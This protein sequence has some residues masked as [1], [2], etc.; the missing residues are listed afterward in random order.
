[1][2]SARRH[3][4][5]CEAAICYTGRHPRPGAH[6]IQPELLRRDGVGAGADGRAH[7]RHQ[8][9][10]RPLQAVRGVRAGEGSARGRRRAGALPHARHQRHSG[11]QR[12]PCRR[13]RRRHRR[14]GA[15]VDE[16]HDE[17]AVSEFSGGCAAAHGARQRARSGRAGPAER[18]L[19]DR[20]RSLL[21]LR[22]RTA[23]A[24]RPTC[25]T[26]RCPAGSSRICASRPRGSV[27]RRAGARWPMP[28]RPP[29]AC[30]ATSSR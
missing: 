17:P 29:T 27:S 4:A 21:S 7:P 9:H 23:C 25:I 1:M 3:D 10:G 11:S 19:V 18:L 24:R 12:A 8:G 20:A 26:T 2:P 14:R 16:R 13:R 5:V 15:G 28:M 6:Q 22:R 30:W